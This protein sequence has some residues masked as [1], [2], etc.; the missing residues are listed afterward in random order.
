MKNGGGSFSAVLRGSRRGGELALP[1]GS[2]ALVP[3][4]G[5]DMAAFCGQ[6]SGGGPGAGVTVRIVSRKG[7]GRGEKKCRGLSAPWA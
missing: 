2:E 4:R 1:S 7:L 6:P 5:S 3:S